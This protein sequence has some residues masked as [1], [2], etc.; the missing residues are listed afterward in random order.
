MWTILF[1]QNKLQALE[2]FWSCLTVETSCIE[3]VLKSESKREAHRF[4]EEF[5]CLQNITSEGMENFL[6]NYFLLVSWY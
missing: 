2:Y 4:K 1:G 5:Y 3:L 6:Q